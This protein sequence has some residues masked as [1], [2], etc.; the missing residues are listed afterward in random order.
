MFASL[1]SGDASPRLRHQQARVLARASSWLVGGRLPAVSSPGRDRE[2]RCPLAWDP[3]VACRM[4]H[5][6]VRPSG[7]QGT[8]PDQVCSCSC[9]GRTRPEA[10]ASFPAL[11]QSCPEATAWQDRAGLCC[12]RRPPGQV[13]GPRTG[14]GCSFSGDAGGCCFDRDEVLACALLAPSSPL[15]FSRGRAGSCWHS[16]QDA[17][18]SCFSVCLCLSLS[19]F[20]SLSLSVSLCLFASVSLAGEGISSDPKP[21]PGLS[22]SSGAGPPLPRSLPGGPSPPA[23]CCPQL[24]GASG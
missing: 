17:T 2:R 19:A 1:G 24:L 21:A 3:S 14:V 7:C 16:K 5:P 12:C 22:P 13:R 9:G 11:L 20:V 23:L 18:P 6:E 10:Q 15:P 4:E 8:S